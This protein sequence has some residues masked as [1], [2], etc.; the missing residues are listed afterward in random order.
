MSDYRSIFTIAKREWHAFFDS[1]VAYVFLVIYLA[2]MG[3]FTFSVSYLYESGNADLRPFFFWHPWL[4]LILVPAIAMRLWSEEKRSGTIELLFTLPI[5]PLQ[6]I[7]GK[8]IAAWGF[9]ITALLLTFPVVLTVYYLGSPDSGVIVSGYLG[10]ALL[11]AAYLAVGMFTSACTRNQVI[12]FILAVVVGL[13]LMLA[14]YPPVTDVLIRFAPIFVVEAVAGL[15]FMPHFEG[16]QRGVVDVRDLL[17]FASVV[18]VLIAATHVVLQ[19]RQSKSSAPTSNTTSLLSKLSTYRVNRGVALGVLL[20]L[21]VLVNVAF[22]RAIWRVDLTEDRLYTISPGTRALLAELDRDVSL[23]FYFSRS[24]DE[25]PIPIRQFAQRVE[26]LLNEYALRSGGR[27]TVESLDPRPDTEVEDWA[28]RYGLHATPVGTVG[29]PF[30]FGV[31]AISGTREAAIPVLSPNQEAELEYNLSRLIQE[32]TRTHQPVVGIISPLPV[33]GSSNP[34]AADHREWIFVQELRRL[35]EVEMLSMTL[36]K[37]PD[38]I[39]LLMVIQPTDIQPVTLY[40]IDQYLMRGGRMIAFLDPWSVAN[41]FLSGFQPQP[42]GG[43][44]APFN[45]LLQAWGFQ[46]DPNQLVA[47]QRFATTLSN[48]QGRP[49]NNVVW[50]SVGRDGMNRQDVSTAAMNELMLAGVG[51]FVGEPVDGIT[52]T[53]LLKSSRASGTV[54]T[55]IGSRRDDGGVNM[56]QPA[57]H[58]QVLAMRLRGRFPSAYPDGRP[59]HPGIEEDEEESGHSSIAHQETS[60][61]DSTVILIADSDILFDEFAVRQINVFGHIM[62][63]PLN[64]NLPF[65]INLIEQMSGNEHLIGLRTRAKFSRPFERVR[66]LEREAQARWQQEEE[67]LQQRMMEVEQ[68]IQQMQFAHQEGTQQLILSAE[69]QEELDR[70]Q[71]ELFETRMQLQDVRRNL[72]REIEQLGI[73]IK[74]LNIVGIPILVGL[75][76]TVKG[77]WRRRRTA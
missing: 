71:E 6:A 17:Y 60:K 44:V 35:H 29:A 54:A 42:H 38:H 75:L 62:F 4:Y 39:D 21:V 30:Y 20:V 16:M 72:R 53:P 11:A 43:N 70:F 63:E 25:V 8:F 50:L 15:S 49:V 45:T 40:A 37:I 1:P 22:S 55:F 67:R 76:G 51:T 77:L 28:Q 12:S 66:E 23:Q 57:D 65:V 68:N 2:L 69:Q 32:A 33:M 19:G 26:E 27:L 14:G 7:L 10:S 9:L 18:T 73:R 41:E 34:N 64:D 58:R 61:A 31:V 5:T 52:K 24:L 46:L 74:A 48:Q 36:P 59:S 47:D 56:V 13:F 3:F